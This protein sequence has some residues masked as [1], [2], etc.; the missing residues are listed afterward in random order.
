MQENGSKHFDGLIFDLDGTLWDAAEACTKAWNK[1]FDELGH[2]HQVNAETVRAVS[3]LRVETIFKEYFGF[4]PQGQYQALL[5]AYKVNETIFVG[6]EGGELFPQV[7]ETLAELHKQYPLFVVSNCLAGYI[8]RF[9]D[10]HHLHGLFTDFECSGNT[11]QPKSENIR[12]LVERNKLQHPVYIGDTVWDQEAAQ[13]ANVPFI[14]AAYG[15]GKIDDPRLT[16]D[17]ITALPSLLLNGST[18]S[19]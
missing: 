4:L 9:L 11:G 13:K 12:L 5:D 6:Q 1:S 16:I 2:T 17:A 18:H 8:E 19:A 7:K 10:F 14:Y 15:F 3:G